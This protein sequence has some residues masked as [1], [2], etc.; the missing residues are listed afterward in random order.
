MMGETPGAAYATVSNRLNGIVVDICNPDWSAI[1]DELAK[2]STE[3]TYEYVLQNVP[4]IN[5]INVYLLNGPATIV[6]Q[7]NEDWIYD[8]ARNSIILLERKQEDGQVLQVEYLDASS[9]QGQQ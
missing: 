1:W 7:E 8:E 6:L 4:I 5:S 2:Y 9:Y 3:P